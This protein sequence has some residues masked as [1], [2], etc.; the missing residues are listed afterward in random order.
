MSVT[1]IMYNAFC[2]HT[3]LKFPG[4]ELLAAGT[5]SCHSEQQEGTGVSNNISNVCAPFKHPKQGAVTVAPSHRTQYQDLETKAAKWHRAIGHF[6][7]YSPVFPA[8]TC[9]EAVKK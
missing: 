6:I 1:Q 8:V 7:I 9:G 4:V 3:L 5:V 2:F